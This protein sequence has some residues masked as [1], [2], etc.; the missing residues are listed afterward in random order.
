V[1]QHTLERIGE[2]GDPMAHAMRILILVH[3]HEQASVDREVQALRALQDVDGGWPISYIYT[4]GST[5]LRIGS[6]GLSTAFAVAALGAARASSRE[7]RSF[8]QVAGRYS[9]YDMLIESPLAA[10][11]LP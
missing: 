7:Y 6:R 9:S 4:Y 8:M 10:D 3:Y 11:D 1:L 2:P 5:G